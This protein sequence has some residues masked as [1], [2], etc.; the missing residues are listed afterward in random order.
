METQVKV[1]YRLRRFTYVAVIGLALLLI[2]IILCILYLYYKEKKDNENIVMPLGELSKRK[3]I[4]SNAVRI[5]GFPG[6]A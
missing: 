4:K 5:K 6:D 3:P 1:D 2:F